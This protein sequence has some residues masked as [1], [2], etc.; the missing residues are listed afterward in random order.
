[1]LSGISYIAAST[2]I[3]IMNLR[4]DIQWMLYY[5]ERHLIP[6]SVP[7]ITSSYKNRSV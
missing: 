5:R 3:S 4:E 2:P 1:M 7:C 6:A